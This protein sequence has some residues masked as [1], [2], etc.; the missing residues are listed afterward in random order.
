[1]PTPKPPRKKRRVAREKE[2]GFCIQEGRKDV[3]HE[4]L[5]TCTECGRSGEHC[6]SHPR[7]CKL[8]AVSI[9]SSQLPADQGLRR[10]SLA[11]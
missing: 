10:H 6:D 5:L 1:M 7:S 2:C 8:I 4:S 3:V 9:R 11:V